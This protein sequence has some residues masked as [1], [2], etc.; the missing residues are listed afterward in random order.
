VASGQPG[1]PPTVQPT[2]TAP[3]SDTIHPTPPDVFS[4]PSDPGSV[5]DGLGLGPD[6]GPLDDH[7][8]GSDNLVPGVGK[9]GEVE[10]QIDGQKKDPMTS[11]SKVADAEVSVGGEEQNLSTMKG[12]SR[13]KSQEKFKPDLDVS[14][15]TIVQTKDVSHPPAS[16][17]PSLKD[18]ESSDSVD[19]S[20]AAGSSSPGDTISHI[21][22]QTHSEVSGNSVKSTESF[23]HKGMANSGKE[24]LLSPS[25]T[26]GGDGKSS[27]AISSSPS[28]LTSDGTTDGS[29]G[30]TNATCLS[31]APELEPGNGKGHLSDSNA[32]NVSSSDN[33]TSNSEKS[34]GSGNQTLS[35]TNSQSNDNSNVDDSKT[36]TSVSRNGTSHSNGSQM[37]ANDTAK[38]G[39]QTGTGTHSGSEYKGISLPS[40]QKERSV[41]LRL[42]NHMEELDSNMT[43]FSIFLNNISSR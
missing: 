15:T 1:T 8:N 35:P 22:T 20:S 27:S 4:P 31:A 2:Y 30:C 24:P 17:N 21:S 34:C 6:L 18:G 42:S 11:E 5:P 36:L 25:P 7:K 3:V 29:T 40:Q 26:S 32:G 39:N 23:A 43:L 16:D 38:T 41:F 9:S 13:E 14:E 12:E 10:G 33:I 28:T 37:E 19:L